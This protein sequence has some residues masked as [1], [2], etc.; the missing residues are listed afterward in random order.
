MS[1]VKTESGDMEAA[2]SGI[3]LGV[4]VEFDDAHKLLHA[5]EAMRDAGFTRWDCHT[6]FPVHGLN[7][8]MGLRPTNLPYFT[9]LCGLAGLT[10]GMLLQWW[11][12]AFDY[13]LNISGKPFWSVPAN[14]PVGFELTILFAALGT[15]IGM[16][17][18]NGLPQ[19]YH[20]VFTSERF[21]RASDDRFF[22]SVDAR[23][24]QFAHAETLE[25]VRALDGNIGVE[26]LFGERAFEPPQLPFD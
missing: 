8:A 13:P 17:V 20:P 2:E 25:F 21:K 19:Y 15:F 3:L 11:M 16:F 1:D 22:I 23:D 24:P 10:L 12:N 7:D 9:F 4:L 26:E 14:I 5:A 18:F 6:P